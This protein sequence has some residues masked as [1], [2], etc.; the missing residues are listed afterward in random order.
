MITAVESRT[1]KRRDSAVF[2]KT[3]EEFGGLKPLEVIERREGRRLWPLT[4]WLRLG[5]PS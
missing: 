5:A 3:N 4:Y 2:C 1:Y